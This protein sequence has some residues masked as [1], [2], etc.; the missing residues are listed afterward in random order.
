MKE[1]IKHVI[2]S[3][4]FDEVREIVKRN[5]KEDRKIHSDAKRITEIYYL[6]VNMESSERLQK[7]QDAALRCPKCQKI[8]WEFFEAE[9]KPLAD[10]QPQQQ[11]QDWRDANESKQDVLPNDSAPTPRGSK[12]R[13]RWGNDRLP[14]RP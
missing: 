1:R 3:D 9:F 4:L 11:E 13:K 6:Y 14:N 8:I 10:E 7:M 2:P 12:K 5:Y